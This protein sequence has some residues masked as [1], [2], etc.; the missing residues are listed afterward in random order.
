MNPK[1]AHLFEQPSL[2]LVVL[3]ER[4]EDGGAAEGVAGEE[5]VV[6]VHLPAEG[7]EVELT[8]MLAE[9]GRTSVLRRAC[10]LNL[11]YPILPS[12]MYRDRQKN[13]P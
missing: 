12:K 1:I 11:G 6:H 2:E 9:G 4:L 13:G 8:L 7:G 5:H 3:V 10:L